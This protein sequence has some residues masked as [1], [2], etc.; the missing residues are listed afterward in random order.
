MSA[1]SFHAAVEKKIRPRELHTYDDFVDCVKQA[2]DP[3]AEVIVMN[4]TDF[5][6]PSIRFKPSIW[7]KSKCRP[8]L[9]EIKV[10]KF[11]KGSY[12]FQY[13]TEFSGDWKQCA[14]FTNAQLKEIKI[15]S[16]NF[17][18]SLNFLEA[19]RGIEESRKANIIKKLCP[20]MPEEKR[21]YWQNL[22]E[23]ENCE[24]F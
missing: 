6:V 22:P 12:E 1:D 21:G 9:N 15:P 7:N 3:E 24:D 16:F 13:K 20:L 2:T 19:C 11:T 4:H 10:V 14:I 23:S 18:S 5:F 17:K 8:K